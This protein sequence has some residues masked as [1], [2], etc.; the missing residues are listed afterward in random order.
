MNYETE[1]LASERLRERRDEAA[2]ERMAR[3]VRQ[4]ATRRSGGRALGWRTAFAVVR[5]LVR[6]APAA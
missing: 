6:L 2:H 5:R 4:P 3:Q 1:F